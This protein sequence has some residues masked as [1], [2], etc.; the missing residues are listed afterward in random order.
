[1][2]TSSRSSD[3]WQV[4]STLARNLTSRRLDHTQQ[5]QPHRSSH[6]F[7]GTGIDITGLRRLPIN[8]YYIISAASSTIPAWPASRPSSDCPSYV[9]LAHPRAFPDRMPSILTEYT[10]GPRDRLSSRHSLC[11][12]L[13][14]LPHA[15]RCCDLRNRTPTQLALQ[16]SSEP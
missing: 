1:M 14:Q 10:K 12:T 9:K 7:A 8:D 5:D 2:T 11:R 3:A 4:G 6:I 13:P 15:P 16:Q